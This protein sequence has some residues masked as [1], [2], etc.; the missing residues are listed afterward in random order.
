MKIIGRL[1]TQIQLKNGRKQKNSNKTFNNS[2][3]YKSLSK[4]LSDFI[5]YRETHLDQCNTIF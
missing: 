2:H 5:L 4:P 1:R 3:F